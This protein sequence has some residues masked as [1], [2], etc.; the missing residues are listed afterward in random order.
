[1]KLKTVLVF[2]LVLM[3]GSWISCNKINEITSFDVIYTLPQTTFTFTPTALKADETLLY[4]SAVE[5]NLD[6]ILTANGFNPGIINQSQFI[7]C[8]VTILEPS[9]E[10]FGWLQSARG[11]ISSNPDFQP[12]FEVGFV[13]NHDPNAKT[14]VFTLNSLNIR[15]YLGAE[16]FYFRIFG[17]LNGT[18]P[19]EFVEM[20]V[21]GA[22]LMHLEPLN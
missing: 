3:I 13:E 12:G 2:L 8:T 1:M 20:A 11:E 18:V 21:N 16:L 17:V 15:P 7:Q 6:S 10:T 14:V 22:L 9:E 5:A 4:Y 19:S